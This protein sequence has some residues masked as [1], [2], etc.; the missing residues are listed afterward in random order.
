MQDPSPASA[1]EAGP[2]E[3]DC[4]R[5]P[6]HLSGAI[7]PHGYLL[8]CTLPDWTVRQ[9]SANVADLLDMPA[10]EVIGR[11]LREHVADDVLEPLLE[12]IDL[13]EPGASPQRAAIGNIGTLAHLCDIG[14]HVANGLV[15]LEL[16]PRAVTST[17]QTPTVVAQRMIARVTAAPDMR[18]FHQRTAEEIRQ[19]TGYDRVMVYRFRHDDAGEVIAEARADDMEPFLGL[20]YPASDIPPQARALYVRNRI[21]VIPD[22][23][24]A[25]VPIVPGRDDQGAPLDLSQHA[26]RSVSPVHLEYLRNMGVAASMSISII[27]GGRLWGL[28]ACHH[29]EPRLVPPALRA[30]ADMFSLFVSMRVSA[31]EQALVSQQ[32]EHARAVRERLALRLSGPDDVSIALAKALP[33]VAEMLPVDGVALRIDGQWQAHGRTPALAG[34][35]RALEW[36]RARGVER[37]P[38]AA[39]AQAWAMPDANDGLAGVLAIPFGRRDDW[40]LYFRC[41]QVEDVVWAGDPTKPMVPT[42]DGVRIAP[43]KSFSSWRETVR[44]QSLPWTEADRSVAERLRWLLQE[45]PWQ[46]LPVDTDNVRDMRVFRRRHVIAEQKSRLDQLGALLDGLG[47]LE[48][49]QTARIGERIAAL[50]A[51]LR[52]LMGSDS[53]T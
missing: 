4:A 44:G 17:R 39:Q 23:H 31:A 18:G 29:R 47:H 52:Q 48:D 30:A 14:V 5:E 37:L 28:I 32:E 49:A 53:M 51:E 45:R 8:S 7:Q 6:I 16:E 1:T 40:L 41:E 50:E 3:A 24:Y 22:A 19:L 36:A 42:D 27:C 2:S 43:R 35:S 12:A 38:H 46:P 10:T 33:L 9:A 11:S 34:L 25:P 21:R 15:H 13:L 20:R 26:L